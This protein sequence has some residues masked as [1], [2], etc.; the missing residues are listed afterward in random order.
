MLTFPAVRAVLPEAPRGGRWRLPWH[1]RY[2]HVVV[3]GRR[4]ALR[5]V[6]PKARSV[7]ADR[8]HRLVVASNIS[9]RRSRRV[10]RRRLI[11][12]RRQHLD[13]P[14][15][16]GRV[17]TPRGNLQRS[18]EIRLSRYRHRLWLPSARVPPQT[19]VKKQQVRTCVSRFLARLSAK[20]VSVASDCPDGEI[21][22]SVITHHRIVSQ[23]FKLS[24]AGAASDIELVWAG[25]LA[26]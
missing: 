5:R 4:A 11:L 26:G 16:W 3:R 21:F 10:L 22:A 12:Q 20:L 7:R 8:V 23:R 18:P 14:P 24:A 6:R 13:L 25:S 1:W 2:H 17:T 9:V 15:G 19:R